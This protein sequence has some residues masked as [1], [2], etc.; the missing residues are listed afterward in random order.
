[1]VHGSQDRLLADPGLA[2]EGEPLTGLI[3][4][5]HLV[6]GA[7]P[8][9]AGPHDSGEEHPGR[10]ATFLARGDDAV[11]QLGVDNAATELPGA[12]GAEVH[13]DLGAGGQLDEYG[14]AARGKSLRGQPQQHILVGGG[15]DSPRVVV[16]HDDVVVEREDDA[17]RAAADPQVLL[18]QLDLLAGG[19]GEQRLPDLHGGGLGE[20]HQQRTGVIAPAGQIHRADGLAGDRVHDRHAGAGEVLEVLCVV[21]MAEHV[22]R[23]AAFQRRA[24][25]VRADELLG[26]AEAGDEQDGVEVAL[27]VGIAGHPGQH[28]PGVVGEHDADRLSGELLVQP[29]QDRVRA[30]REGRVQVG[31][32][33][34]R[35]LDAVGGHVAAL[36]P[37]PRREDAL[38]HLAGRDR[39]GGEEAHAGLRQPGTIGQGGRS[40]LC[41]SRRH[42][43]PPRC[44]SGLTRPTE[45]RLGPGRRANITPDRR[46]TVSN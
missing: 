3:D 40:G 11:R 23:L 32:A 38:A 19:I 4:V 37:Q 15:E 41:G 39:L 33:H 6:A 5:L 44:V 31:V 17:R 8:Q 9:G 29:A 46:D 24:Y 13:L 36:G 28:E 34:V 7:P 18:Q 26:I 16:H 12:E 10:R 14:V 42:R 22:H 1:L 43:L 35:H 45:G 25:P 21:L 30:A 20:C 2:G 27:E